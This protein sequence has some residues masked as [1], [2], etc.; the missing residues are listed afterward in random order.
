M[1]V[2]LAYFYLAKKRGITILKGGVKVLKGGVTILEPYIIY[3]YVMHVLCINYALL[4]VNFS[5]IS[6]YRIML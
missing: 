6:L 1:I 2:L 4:S 5:T 3:T